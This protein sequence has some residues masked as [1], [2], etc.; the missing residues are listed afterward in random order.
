MLCKC[1]KLFSHNY[2]Y[3][4]Y[5]WSELKV[6][7]PHCPKIILLP[8][9]RINFIWNNGIVP[10]SLRSSCCR[11]FNPFFSCLKWITLKTD[12]FSVLSGKHF[13]VVNENKISDLQTERERLINIIIDLN[14]FDW[15]FNFDWGKASKKFLKSDFYHFGAETPSPRK[16]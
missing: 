2:C 9:V 6:R 15:L 11:S 3:K 8:E 13:L 7:I 5:C 1:G 10:D 14:K 16:W 12:I 4:A